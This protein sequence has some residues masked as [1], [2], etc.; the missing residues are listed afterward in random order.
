MLATSLN[1][2]NNPIQ[3][4]HAAKRPDQPPGYTDW[5]L[6]VEGTTLSM[7]SVGVTYILE[8][9][10]L[11]AWDRKDMI[12]FLVTAAAGKHTIVINAKSVPYKQDIVSLAI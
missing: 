5:L 12:T 7:E 8:M 6:W 11:L 1:W 3:K 4:L 2:R 9:I 10:E